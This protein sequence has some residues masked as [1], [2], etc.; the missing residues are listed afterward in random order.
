MLRVSSSFLALTVAAVLAGCG[1]TDP[2]PGPGRRYVPRVAMPTDLDS[3]EEA[4][5][6]DVADVLGDAGYR[7]TVSRSAEYQLE[8]SVEP[9]PVNVDVH[10]E[11]HRNGDEVVKTFARSGGLTTMFKKQRV[12]RSAFDK[13]LADFQARL[14][15]AGA[16]GPSGGYGGAGGYEEGNWRD[17]GGSGPGRSGRSGG[18]YDDAYPVESGSP[19]E[20]Q[21]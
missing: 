18:G 17:S 5:I 14:P 9:G 21:R 7:P 3:Q 1:S 20:D 16:G 15:Q 11:L 12:I 8:F 19:Y 13:A 4:F 6:D 10:I 2:D